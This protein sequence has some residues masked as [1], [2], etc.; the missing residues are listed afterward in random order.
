[1]P[2]VLMQVLRTG[3]VCALSLLPAAVATADEPR[4]ASGS[5]HGHEWSFEAFGA[6]A[7]PAKVGLDDQ[8]GVRVAVSNGRFKAAGFD[9]IWDREHAI[10]AFFV[11]DETLV[12]YFDFLPS[13]KYAGLHYAFGSGDG[14]GYCYD[15]TVKSTVKLSGGHIQGQLSLPAKEGE[16]SF[17]VSFDVPV[18]SSDYGKP[19][20]ADFGE[21]GKVYAAYHQ[22][23]A[24]TPAALAP[25]LPASEAADL[26]AHG[27]GILASRREGHPTE[28]YRITR[29]WVQ[30]ERALL[31]VEGETSYAKVKTEVLLVRE[32]GSWKVEDEI[33][34][35]RLGDG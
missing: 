22:A 14:C 32:E 30:G 35:V 18:A 26:G 4:Q 1:M 10:D 5:F 6:Y 19:L 8:A 11:D 3:A 12:V 2:R 16:V 23:L 24:A 33:L 34:Q 25:L 31:L 27:D 21:P 13:G 15:G 17:D 20:A 29:G 7:F 9:P 28:S